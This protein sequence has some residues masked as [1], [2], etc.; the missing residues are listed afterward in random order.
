[1]AAKTDFKKTLDAYQAKRGEFRVVDV[2]TMQYLMIDGHGDPNTAAEFSPRDRGALPGRVQAQVRE[3]GD[4]GRDYV[5]MPLEALWWS[6]DMATF[7]APGTSPRW[8]WTL[9]IMTPDWITRRSVRDRR[10]A[11]GAKASPPARLGEV[12]L[13]TLA[14]G[15]CVQTL[16]V[17]SFDDEAETLAPDARRVHSG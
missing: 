15:R 10:R 17:G 1:M 14:E 12:R 4:L 16:H 5:V 13:E 9:M 11:G 6:A 3:Q 2:P 8:D 7:T